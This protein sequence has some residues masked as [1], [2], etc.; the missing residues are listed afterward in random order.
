VAFSHD[1]LQWTVHNGGRPILPKTPSDDI[2]SAGYD[3]LRKRYFLIG[4]HFGPC[5]WINAE[6]ETLTVPI[7]RY[8]TSFSPDFKTWSDPEGL[9]YSPDE[10]DSGI[11][12]WYGAAGF[13]VRGDLIVGFL[14]VL[15]DDLSP[16]G[17]P[18]EALQANNSGSASLGANLL[19][20]RGGSGMGYT[21]LTW[22][23]DGVTWERDRHT[24][25]FFEPD[26]Q[27][28]AW[29]HAMAWIGSS[30][31]VDD[32]VYLYYAGYRW[33]HK[34]RHSVDRQIGLVK[35]PR[36]RYVA[37]QAGPEGGTIVTPVLALRGDALSLNVDADGGEV[38]L[39]VS[40]VSGAPIPGFLYADCRPV[41]SDSLAADIEW[42]GRLSTLRDRPV[43]LELLL[44]NARLFALDVR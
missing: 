14:R 3:P 24:D 44:R 31:A 17:V 1:G 19:G 21:V 20:K 16:A 37:R 18:E 7:R 15:R 13:Q 26:P 6:G 12:Q 4:K 29:D 25:A 39:Q 38:R 10:R 41:T 22:T 43:R 27:L 8:F 2:W 40:D 5:T 34:Y 32:E 30:V 9:I 11:T 36:N 23:R 35:V 33:G 28:G 42:S